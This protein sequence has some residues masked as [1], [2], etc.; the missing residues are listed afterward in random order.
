MHSHCFFGQHMDLTGGLSF[1]K[2][3]E[4]RDRDSIRLG[5]RRIYCKFPLLHARNSMG[6]Q[7]LEGG[8]WKVEG[9]KIKES[10]GGR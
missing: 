4:K 10:E 9:R 3:K 2:K 5:M 8:R 1:F 6:R 7:E